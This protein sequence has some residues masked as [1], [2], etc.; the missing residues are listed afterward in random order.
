M[1]MKINQIDIHAFSH[2]HVTFKDNKLTI[3]KQTVIKDILVIEIEQQKDLYIEIQPFSEVS[4]ILDSQSIHK[5]AYQYDVHVEVM[6]SSH[7][8]FVVI[9]E[10]TG[11]LKNV[12]QTINV[13]KNSNLHVVG[14]FISESLH[15]DLIIN[16]KGEQSHVM[17]HGIGLSTQTHEQTI[18]VHMT[19]FAP[20]SYGDMYNVGIANQKGK[21]TLNGIEKI[22]QGM[23][24]A[25]AFQTLKGIILSDQAIV[26][27]NPILLIDEY[28][29]KAGHGATIGKL[30]AEQLYYLQSRGLTKQQAEKLIIHGFIKP[31]IEHIKDEVIATRIEEKIFNSL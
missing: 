4:I 20:Y 26:N 9:Q 3:L 5:E 8:E 13:H 12:T 6:E 30:E 22:E 1:P 29:V 25:H 21:L 10:F 27:V 14:A 2:P 19:H 31:I 28:D 24:Q 16:L 11:A 17:V 18:D 15:T 23:K 7:V